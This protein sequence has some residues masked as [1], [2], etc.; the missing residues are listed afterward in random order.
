MSTILLLLSVNWGGVEWNWGG[1]GWNG[2][3]WNKVEWNWGGVN[4]H[5]VDHKF[6]DSFI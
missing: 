1:V 3:G 5:L 2:T 6:S 4:T